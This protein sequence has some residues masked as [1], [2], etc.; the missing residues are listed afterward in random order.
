MAFREWKKYVPMAKRRQQGERERQRAGKQG[1]AM[2]PVRAEGRKLATTPWG[3]A[4]CRHIESF[5]DYV[6]RLPRGR[7]YLRNGS[8]IDVQVGTGEIRAKVMGSSLY[9]QR[10]TIEPCAAKRWQGIVTRC[11]GQVGS[12]VELLEGRFPATLM[13][14]LTAEQD[15]LLPDLK[16]VAMSCSCPD[17]ATLCKHLA[18]VLYGIGV[19]FDEDA[20]LLFLL[21]G[22]DPNQLINVATLTTLPEPGGSELTGDL[23]AIFGVDLDLDF[24]T[25]KPV[26]DTAAS[27]P[28]KAPGRRASTRPPAEPVA[29]ARSAAR[30]KARPAS[31]ASPTVRRADLLRLGV[32][33]GTIAT[34]LHL[35]VLLPGDARGVY[36]HTDQSRQRLA[37]RNRDA[38]A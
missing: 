22:V 4:W 32:P 23:S 37:R 34:W 18:A 9:E 13:T 20:T 19:R 27:P 11:G 5:H 31:D 16:Q 6:N 17:W 25:T 24:G 1:Q 14:A 36:Q 10:I 33:P 15:G 12:L 2:H 35:G 21:R 26:A 28:R 7:T 38:D 29:P 30:R 3:L 8:V